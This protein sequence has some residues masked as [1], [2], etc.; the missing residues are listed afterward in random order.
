MTLTEGRQGRLL[1]RGP[2]WLVRKAGT[3]R[4]AASLPGG[5]AR[6]LIQV[7]LAHE[8]DE[9]AAGAV[10]PGYARDHG[11]F[12]VGVEANGLRVPGLRE[13]PSL[14]GLLSLL[15]LVR[16][17]GLP[18]S[19]T[20]RAHKDGWGAG[21]G[22]RSRLAHPGGG[23]GAAHTVDGRLLLSGGTFVNEGRRLGRRLILACGLIRGGRL[24]TGGLVASG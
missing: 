10:I 22:R 23:P 4:G 12:L 17:I 21:R 11:N 1:F 5:G 13:R 6:H 7:F 14:A 24:P 8:T 20:R 19:L 16:L 3:A 2:V 18:G 9:D 15:K